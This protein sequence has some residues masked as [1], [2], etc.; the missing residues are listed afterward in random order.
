MLAFG[1]IV[2]SGVRPDSELAF[3]FGVGVDDELELVG[4]LVTIE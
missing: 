2:D 3:D 1:A 4:I